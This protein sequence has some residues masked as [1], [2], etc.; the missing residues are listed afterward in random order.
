MTYP[1]ISK[2]SNIASRLIWL[3]FLGVQV[4]GIFLSGSVTAYVGFIFGTSVWFVSFLHFQRRFIKILVVLILLIL[5]ILLMSGLIGTYVLE[6]RLNPQENIIARSLTRVQS[7]TALSRMQVYFNSLKLIIDSPIIGASFDQ[8][9]TS[10]LRSTR[11]LSYSVHNSLLQ[12]WYVGGIFAFLGY[13]IIYFKLGVTA[14]K[15]LF[16]KIKSG[17]P[18]FMSSAAAATLSI[19]IMDQFQDGIYQREKWLV[20]AILAGY[21]YWQKHGSV[22]P[23]KKNQTEAPQQEIKHAH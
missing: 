4:F 9:A 1:L 23:A 2:R 12:I 22:P 3:A 17:I 11:T 5:P 6:F 8:L 7:N 14:L 21:A 15:A 10:D 19:M 20:I 16:G 13:I 18:P